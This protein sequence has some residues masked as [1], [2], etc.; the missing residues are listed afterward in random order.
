MTASSCGKLISSGASLLFRLSS[1]CKKI[2]LSHLF[3]TQHIIHVRL[4][5]FSTGTMTNI[6][7]F[8]RHTKMES[9]S[10]TCILETEEGK[11][12][13]TTYIIQY[14]I[15]ASKGSDRG[16]EKYNLTSFRV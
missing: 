3:E 16:E 13:K 10:C 1:S 4:Y 9:E 14:D 6:C 11:G 7:A 12:F 5:N 8:G 2:I 15:N